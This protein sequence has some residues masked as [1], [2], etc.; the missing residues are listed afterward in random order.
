MLESIDLFTGIGGLTRALHGIMRPVAYCDSWDVAQR[1]IRTNIERGLLPHAP[2][3]GD[4]RQLTR[5]WLRQHNKN[6][7]PTAVIGG[8][9]CTGFS[10]AGRRDG[11]ANEQSSLFHE[12]IRVVQ[13]FRPQVVFLEN[14]PEILNLG[15]SVVAEELTRRGYALRWAVFPASVVGA[16]QL[17]K[18]WFCLATLRPFRIER[19][20]AYTRH[21]WSRPPQRMT[22]QVTKQRGDRCSLL[23]NSVVPDCVRYAFV[24]L[25]S[26]MPQGTID[27]SP[28]LLSLVK[29]EDQLILRD[30]DLKCLKRW[31]TFGFMEKRVLRKVREP[32]GVW[33][34]PS[35]QLVFDPRA[36]VSKTISPPTQTAERLRKP[37]IRHNWGTP[38]H[39]RPAH[40]GNNVLTMRN[41]RDL[42][43]QVR[44][45]VNTPD[46]LRAGQVSA[47]F[48]EYLMGYPKGYTKM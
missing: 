33:K 2:I 5:Y 47:E 10:A 42:A 15:M 3:C 46:H 48:V 39:N 25:A 12:L 23:G 40:Y 35:V 36:F 45:E 26:G 8:F 6:A 24:Y 4:V 31:P 41:I 22:L 44:F 14:V 19:L 13:E 7:K 32:P 20:P 38:R 17:R 16:P 34:L 29:V 21:K 30:I 11:L 9:P 28:S 1:S 43:T 18:R 27:L 37:V